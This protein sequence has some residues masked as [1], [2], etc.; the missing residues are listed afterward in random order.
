MLL[1][2]TMLLKLVEKLGIARNKRKGN[3]FYKCLYEETEVVLEESCLVDIGRLWTTLTSY[4][5]YLE[6]IEQLWLAILTFVIFYNCLSFVW[7]KE[8]RWEF[9]I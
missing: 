6:G 2:V 5:S 9:L 4:E 3:K 8:K 1:V 7:R